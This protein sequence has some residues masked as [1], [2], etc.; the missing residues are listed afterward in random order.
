MRMADDPDAVGRFVN[1]IRRRHEEKNAA[2][3]R[4]K[5]GIVGLIA[6]VCMVLFIGLLLAIGFSSWSG[7]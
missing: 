4:D 1:R 5:A 7:V 3:S 2:R 6:L